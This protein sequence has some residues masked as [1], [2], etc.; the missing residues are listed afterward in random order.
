M[1]L[2]PARG[3]RQRLTQ[4]AGFTCKVFAERNL[5]LKF[6]AK[7]ILRERRIRKP[8]QNWLFSLAEYPPGGGKR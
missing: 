6:L 4:S 8:L 2:H 5:D 1:N 7:K 3:A